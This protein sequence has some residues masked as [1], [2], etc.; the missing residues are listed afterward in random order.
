MFNARAHRWSRVPISLSLLGNIVIYISSRSLETFSLLFQF[1]VLKEFSRLHP[2]VPASLFAQGVVPVQVRGSCNFLF[3]LS[4]S[5]SPTAFLGQSNGHAF[6]QRSSIRLTITPLTTLCQPY[7]FHRS[8]TMASSSPSNPE[9]DWFRAREAKRLELFQRFAR[10]VEAQA[11][12]E[13]NMMAR[14]SRVHQARKKTRQSR[15]A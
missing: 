12:E 3:K 6:L 14:C 9:L 2:L 4:F 11:K 7:H 8:K 1:H 5:R 15:T 10:T 13:A